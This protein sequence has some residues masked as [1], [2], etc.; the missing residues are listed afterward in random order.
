MRKG[1]GAGVEL[2]TMEEWLEHPPKATAIVQ[3]V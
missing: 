3:I 2:P 1:N